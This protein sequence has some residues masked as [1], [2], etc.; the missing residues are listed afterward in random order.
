MDYENNAADLQNWKFDD[1]QQC[2]QQ[3]LS[4]WPVH[5][6]KPDEEEYINE[7]K[8]IEKTSA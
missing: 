6:T 7:L 3:R 4:L 2:L 1:M 5:K 8:L